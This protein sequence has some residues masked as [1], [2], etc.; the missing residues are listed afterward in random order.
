MTHVL[1]APMLDPGAGRAGLVMPEGLTLAE[2]VSL[3]LP[4]L[5]DHGMLRVSLVNSMCVEVIDPACWRMV[6]PKPGIRVVIRAIPEGD[7]LRSVLSIVISVAAI[8]MG[9]AWGVQL[10]S[11]LGLS[12]TAGTALVT[13]GVTVLGNLALNALI[14]PPKPEEQQNR[15]TISG[16]RNRLEPDGAVPVVLGDIRYAPPFAAPS[17]TEII[18]D[19]QYV[20]ALFCFGYGPLEISDIRIGDTPISEFRD[21]EIQ[22]R[23]GYPTANPQTLYPRQVVEEAIG[24]ELTRPRPRNASGDVVSGPSIISPV[25]R[26]TGDDAAGASVILSFPAGMVRFDKKSRKRSRSVEIRIRQRRAGT[27]PWLAE[28][29]INISGSQVEAMFREHSW[30]FPERGRWEI[31]ITRMTDETDD[32][33]ISDR[34][35]WAALQ[36]LRP[37]YPLDFPEPLALIAMRIRATHQINGSLDNISARVRRVC[38]DYDHTTGTWVRRPTNNPASLFRYVLQSRANPRPVTNAELDLDQLADWHDFCRVKGL[39]FNRVLDQAGGTLRDALAEICGAGRASPR[40]DGMRWGV[41]IDRPR[42]LIVDHISPRNSWNFKATRSYVRPPH[43][44]RVRFLDET[45]D[46]GAAERLVPWPGHSGPIELTEVLD[47]PGKTHPDEIW[48]EARRRMYE[49][50]HRPD[51]YEVTQDGPLRVATRGDLV[52]LS[53]DVLDGTQRAARVKAVQGTSVFLDESVEIERGQSYAIRWRQLSAGDTIGQSILR[54]VSAPPGETNELTLPAGDAPRPGDL[55]MFGR[56]AQ[57]TIEAIVTGIE[58]TE[59]HACILR[60]V[61]AAPQIDALTDADLP[62]PF[63][64]RAGGAGMVMAEPP[65][66]PHWVQVVSGHEALLE[67]IRSSWTGLGENRIGY[68]IRAGI[69]DVP[70]VRFRIAHRLA[71]A[72]GWTYEHIP[73]AAGGGEITSYM[74]GDKVELQAQAISAS[75]IMSAATAILSVTIGEDDLIVPGQLDASR[76]S[77]V[78]MLGA[79][80][81]QFE[82]PPDPS[83]ASVQIYLSTSPVLDRQTDAAGAPVIVQP[84]RQVVSLIGDGTRRNMIAG[85]AMGS[86][87]PWT[88]GA[89]WRIEDGAA[90][91]DPG[92]AGG[93]GQS[94]PLD[95]GTVYRLAYTMAGV[96]GGTLRPRL[97]GGALRPGVERAGNGRWLDRLSAVAG[98]D[99]FALWAMHDFAGRVDDVVLYAETA[100]CLAQGRHYL[101]LEPRNADDVPGPLAGPFEIDLE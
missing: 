53:Q 82:T 40:H 69:G 86:A 4:G 66:I 6:R 8:A 20:R 79:I 71:G 5:S 73:A 61:D 32:S 100:N 36:T 98:N 64:G 51:T 19:W 55:V 14:P 56:A 87:A 81:V 27:T 65:A 12:A 11:A 26:V 39:A 89:G 68:R 43:G 78:P 88:L 76:V 101:W 1:V 25:V 90:H 54:P 85:S 23:Q 94:L 46:F 38:Q 58:T 24:V 62:P 18:G 29:V 10:G 60:L 47:L 74:R 57:V 92:T 21:V 84:S 22:V 48:T 42:D 72:T 28:Q 70:T 95:A 44:F 45:A 99:G 59:D 41:V 91:H 97:T 49:A 34:S 63:D 96:T 35:V 75:G 30:S 16:W 15:Y 77:L 37:E 83:I 33:A 3:A 2:M 17:Y 9:Q 80:N 67:Q 7:G 50:I 31:E 93:L 52:A 13:L